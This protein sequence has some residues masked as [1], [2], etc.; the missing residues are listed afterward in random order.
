MTTSKSRLFGGILLAGLLLL[1]FESVAQVLA[2]NP[3]LSLQASFDQILGSGSFS[4]LAFLIKGLTS[5]VALVFSGW[6]VLGIYEATLVEGQ[7]SAKA[8]MFYL[9]RLFAI[10]TILIILLNQ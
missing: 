9:L 7:V 8:G 1:S 4:D 6:A 10:L 2:P 5:A 3:S